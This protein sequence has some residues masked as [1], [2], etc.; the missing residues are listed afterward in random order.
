MLATRGTLFFGL[1]APNLLDA[2]AVGL[3]AY[4]G[5]LA[6]ATQRQRSAGRP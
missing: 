2:L 6:L 5:A 1:G 3:L 4:A